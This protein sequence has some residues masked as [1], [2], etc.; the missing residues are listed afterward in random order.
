VVLDLTDRMYG[1]GTYAEAA[2][3][4]DEVLAPRNGLLRLEEFFEAAA[5]QI[6]AFQDPEGWELADQFADAAAQFSDL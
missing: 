2:A 4:L 6:S 1:S 3:A 5:E